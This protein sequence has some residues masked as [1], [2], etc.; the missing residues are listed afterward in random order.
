VGEHHASGR[1]AFASHGDME[2]KAPSP[3]LGDQ[4]DEATFKPKRRWRSPPHPLGAMADATAQ[5]TP[6]VFL[7]GKRPT[8]QDCGAGGALRSGTPASKKLL[9]QLDA[10]AEPLS[11]HANPA[12]RQR[13]T[14]LRVEPRL[15][16]AGIAV[17]CV[18]A[19]PLSR[20]VSM[21]LLSS[22]GRRYCT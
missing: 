15:R 5:W 9:G 2:A 14:P 1:N 11:C 21:W 20:E 12:V 10:V 19:H 8:A 17:R 22:P 16:A 4:R 6:C 13:T 3:V 7:P 18:G